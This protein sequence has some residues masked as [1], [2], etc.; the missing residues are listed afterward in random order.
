M[1][2]YWQVDNYRLDAQGRPVDH[3]CGEQYR[4]TRRV[5]INADGIAERVGEEEAYDLRFI[6]RT[7]AGVAWVRTAP[8]S[9]E[10]AETDLRVLM[11]LY[12]ESISGTGIMLTDLGAGRIE[13]PSF[14][15]HPAPCRCHFQPLVIY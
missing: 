13:R 1:G 14:S 11:R 15:S 9:S 6:S 5:D 8:L 10:L 4:V 3:K 7:H 2:A 12:V